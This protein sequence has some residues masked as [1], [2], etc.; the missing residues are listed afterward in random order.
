MTSQEAAKEAIRP[1][2]DL[3]E[4]VLKMLRAGALML[5]QIAERCGKRQSTMQELLG[6]LERRGVVTRSGGWREQH[7]AL[8]RNPCVG[9]SQ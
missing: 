5:P 9:K 1:L 7:W 2:T 3:E 8:V 4:R 6:R